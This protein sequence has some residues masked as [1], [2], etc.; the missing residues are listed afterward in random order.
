MA[1]KLNIGCTSYN[2]GNRMVN[3]IRYN[4]FSA[5][6]I[7]GQFF[8]NKYIHFHNHHGGFLAKW[9]QFSLQMPRYLEPMA[10]STHSM[11]RWFDWFE[12]SVSLVGRRFLSQIQARMSLDHQKRQGF[13]SGP[14]WTMFLTICSWM[15]IELCCWTVTLHLCAKLVKS[16]WW[17]YQ[18]SS[19]SPRKGWKKARK[20]TATCDIAK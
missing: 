6:C 15:C 2:L 10:T 14:Q 13:W 5:N 7:V 3:Y 18:W 20:T 4:T 19:S 12:L 17:K 9:S 11:I 8:L 1:N 16:W